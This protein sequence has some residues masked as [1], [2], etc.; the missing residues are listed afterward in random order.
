MANFDIIYSSLHVKM[1]S[2]RVKSAGQC[3]VSAADLLQ[4]RPG[5]VRICKSLKSYV[6]NFCVTIA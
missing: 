5:N 2:I 1:C 3:T 6:V 4:R